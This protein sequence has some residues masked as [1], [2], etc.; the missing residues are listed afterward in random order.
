M[1]L[2]YTESFSH[3]SKS[4]ISVACGVYFNSRVIQKLNAGYFL[5]VLKN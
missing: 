1:I 3:L 2:S 4:L 5:G